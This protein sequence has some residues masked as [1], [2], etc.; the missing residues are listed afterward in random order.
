MC[1]LYEYDIMKSTGK[2]R[3]ARGTHENLI[4]LP[5][6]PARSALRK[7]RDHRR[8]WLE[9]NGNPTVGYHEIHEEHEEL[10]PSQACHCPT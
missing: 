2:L 7:K 10:K 4:Y 6:P 3:F 8:L 9:C 5:R 1:A